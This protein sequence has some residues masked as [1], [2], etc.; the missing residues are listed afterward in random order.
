LQ[1]YSDQEGKFIQQNRAYMK[2]AQ[3]LRL[4]ENLEVVMGAGIGFVNLGI[5]SNA[6]TGAYSST[7][8]D[9]KI[10]GLLKTNRIQTNLAYLQLLD[11]R[12]TLISGELTLK[13]YLLSYSTYQLEISPDLELEPGLY[14][15]YVRGWNPDI[16]FQGKVLWKQSFYVQGSG[17]YGNGLIIGAGIQ[18]LPFS[19]YGFSFGI[20]YRVI[21]SKSTVLKSNTLE[22]TLGLNMKTNK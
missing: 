20:S 14:V 11:S 13:R 17:N 10:G 2:Y 4:R 3:F 18:D 19:E 16:R 22:I 6:A 15:R 1:G 7:K 5:S 21:N 8:I 12:L 9:F